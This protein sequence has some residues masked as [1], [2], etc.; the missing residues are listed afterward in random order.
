MYLAEKCLLE[1]ETVPF[2]PL[3][4]VYKHAKFQLSNII[5]QTFLE[6]GGFC[7]KKARFLYGESR[8]Y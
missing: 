4:I 1:A 3:I 2:V 7:S 5:F 6:G 8:F